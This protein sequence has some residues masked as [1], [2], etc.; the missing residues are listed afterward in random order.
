ML[1]FYA[2]LPIV[3]TI[4]GHDRTVKVILDNAAYQ[5]CYW[6]R[7]FASL[8]GIEL[9]FFVMESESVHPHHDVGVGMV[10]AVVINGVKVF[11]TKGNS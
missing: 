7:S 9:I 10:K 3:P 1:K 6:V 4:S 2:V 8:I 11:G 5:R